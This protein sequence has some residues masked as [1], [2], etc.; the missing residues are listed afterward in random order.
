MVDP[1]TTSGW[2]PGAPIKSDIAALAAKAREQNRLR[3]AE[4]LPP[5]TLR[6]YIIPPEHR[7]KILQEKPNGCNRG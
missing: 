5:I 7:G 1:P 4:K 3:E 2:G 6:D